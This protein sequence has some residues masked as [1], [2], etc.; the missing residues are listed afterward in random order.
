MIEVDAIYKSVED[1]NVLC[2]VLEEIA[3]GNSKEN[4]ILVVNQQGEKIAFLKDDF[5]KKFKEH[6]V[7]LSPAAHFE[8]KID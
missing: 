2:R 3:I 4:G 6:E 1:D 5:E 8:K 7:P